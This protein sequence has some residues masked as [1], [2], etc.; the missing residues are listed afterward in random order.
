[1]AY[2]SNYVDGDLNVGHNESIGGSLNVQGKTTLRGGVK[3]EGFLEAEFIKCWIK[4]LFQTLNDLQEAYPDPQPGWVAYVGTIASHTMFAVLDGEWVHVPA[5]D[6]SLTIT[7][8]LNSYTDAVNALRALLASTDAQIGENTTAIASLQSTTQ[9]QR[10][11]ISNLSDRIG[12]IALNNDDQFI[13]LKE[14]EAKVQHRYAESITGLKKI[15]NNG[16]ELIVPQDGG[17]LAT[18]NITD[19][20]RSDIAPLKSAYEK[21]NKY[22][23]TSIVV[24]TEAE[25]E[26]MAEAGTLT[27]DVLYLG[28]ETEE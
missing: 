9:D 19:K 23:P 5:G 10:K 15:I 26:A 21:V 11:S 22:A 7:G 8:D 16:K 4:G 1:M 13:R 17:T 6:N 25:L 20:L 18:T 3:I 2:K 14:L 24:M 12:K 27:D 28:L